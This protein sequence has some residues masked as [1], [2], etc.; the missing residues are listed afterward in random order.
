MPVRRLDSS[1]FKWPTREDVIRS[2]KAW[3]S[4]VARSSS[5]VVRIGY[6]GSLASGNW[7]VGSDVDLIVVV[8]S[9]N[10][11]FLGRAR[12]CDVTSLPVPADLLV[13]TYE[14]IEVS[15]HLGRIVWIYERQGEV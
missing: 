6:R 13:Y 12:D 7:G 14:E 15:H 1:V 3:A 11:D 9:T 2:V 4:S 10:R 8:G 5:I